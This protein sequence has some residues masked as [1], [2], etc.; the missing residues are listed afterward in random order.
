MVEVEKNIKKREGGLRT[1]KIGNNS[2][3]N[4]PLFS[5]I[6]VVYNGEQHLEQTITSVINQKFN[7]LEYIIIDGGSIDGSLEIIEKYSDYIDYWVSESDN[8]IYEAMN[9]GIQ[10]AGGDLIALLNA[11]DFYEL[12]A[13]EKISELYNSSKTEAIYFGNNYIIQDD[14]S[15]K[16]KNYATQEFSKGMAICH[17]AM[18]VHRNIYREVGA[19]SIFYQ[20]ASDYDLVLRAAEKKV[21]FIFLDEFIVNYRNTGRT[22]ISY[23]TSL[24][25]AREINRH[26]YGIF[27]FRHIK[28]VVISFRSLALFSLQK[29]IRYTFGDKLLSS[30]RLIY[31][32]DYLLKKDDIVDDDN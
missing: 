3:E 20:Y 2:N 11:D 27:S 25:E 18:F 17:Q 30:L 5:I 8:G 6:T 14:L 31:M 10:L 22:S 26:H 23:K 16:Y 24:N 32:K 13:L 1:R 7:N 4:A 29:I 9:K 21:G 15:L 19:Y 12:D 28:F